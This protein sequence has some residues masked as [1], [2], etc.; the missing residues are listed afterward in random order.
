M[1]HRP[2]PGSH[3]GI[4]LCQAAARG[5]GRPLAHPSPCPMSFLDL[6]AP[7]RASDASGHQ[8]R[9]FCGGA[10]RRAV[11]STTITDQGAGF[12]SYSLRTLYFNSNSSRAGIF[13]GIS[14]FSEVVTV[15][16]MPPKG[17]GGGLVPL[18]AAMNNLALLPDS[19]DKWP[20]V[21]AG[22]TAL[23]TRWVRTLKG[24]LPG[25]GATRVW[26]GWGGW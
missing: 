4:A 15:S 2:A 8:G 22:C 3:R 21:P 19:V 10:K 6:P 13:L 25:G 14:R 16:C 18:H 20:V 5:A 17:V 7:C 12:R 1:A 9:A 23:S 11:E 24:R 26:A